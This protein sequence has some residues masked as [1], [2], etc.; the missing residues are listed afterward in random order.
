MEGTFPCSCFVEDT[1]F[2]PFNQSLRP[3]VH[4]ER[5]ELHYYQWVPFLFVAQALLFL[6]PRAA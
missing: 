1:Y 5:H 4:R 6:L 2:V 3:V